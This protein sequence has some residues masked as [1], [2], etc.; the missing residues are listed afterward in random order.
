MNFKFLYLS[1]KTTDFV[2]KT[3]LDCFSIVKYKLNEALNLRDSN[4]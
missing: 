2:Q 1:E 3:L 4:K